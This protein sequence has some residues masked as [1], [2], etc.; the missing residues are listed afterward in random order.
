MKSENVS[1]DH[2]KMALNSA[3]IILI[4]NIV[5]TGINVYIAVQTAEIRDANLEIQ[6]HML[7]NATSFV[8]ARA[9]DAYLG[10]PCLYLNQSGIVVQTVHSGN[11]YVEVQVMAAYYSVLTIN[12][13][14][15]DTVNS[16]YLNLA[17]LNETKICYSALAERARERAAGEEGYIT[18]LVPGMNLLRPIL[19]LKAEVYPNPERLPPAE[20]GIQFMLG[21]LHMEVEISNIKTEAVVTEEFLASVFITLEAPPW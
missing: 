20:E 8:I 11:M 21:T 1:Q 7:E 4:I 10:K 13:A 3:V 18:I 15:F 12:L 17:R 19:S 2:K 9:D 14:R 6:S 16:E 5:L